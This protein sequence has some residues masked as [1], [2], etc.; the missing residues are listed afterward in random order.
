MNS[1]AYLTEQSLA[2]RYHRSPQTIARWRKA[3]RGPKAV[4]IGGRI[5][6]AVSEVQ[7]FERE[8]ATDA[9]VAPDL[10]DE[11]DRF[12]KLIGLHLSADSIL[13]LGRVITNLEAEELTESTDTTDI[14]VA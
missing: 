7:K 12:A 8:E 1:Q 14:G 13:Q 2:E 5:L 10:H 4:K 3:G 11:L 6:Y 9:G